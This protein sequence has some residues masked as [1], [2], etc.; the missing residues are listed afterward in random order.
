MRAKLGTRQDKNNF[1]CVLQATL[2]V[3]P[4][5]SVPVHIATSVPFVLFMNTFGA[6]ILCLVF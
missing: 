6:R 1:P 3:E 2:Q 5:C 4:S